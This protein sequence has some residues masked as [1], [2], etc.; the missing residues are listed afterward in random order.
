MLLTFLRN[1]LSDKSLLRLEVNIRK[2]ELSVKTNKTE[3]YSLTS[4]NPVT[5]S[6]WSLRR[7]LERHLGAVSKG[8]IPSKQSLQHYLSIPLSTNDPLFEVSEGRLPRSCRTPG[9]TKKQ[10]HAGIPSKA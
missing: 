6:G 9:L 3:K 8:W 2:K 7:K 10:I 4:E 5:G 1:P